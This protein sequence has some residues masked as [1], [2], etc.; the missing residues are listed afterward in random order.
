M[1]AS[2]SLYNILLY[3][4]ALCG[5]WQLRENMPEHWILLTKIR[6]MTA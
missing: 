1:L 4:F 6:R 2:M 3:L 5:V